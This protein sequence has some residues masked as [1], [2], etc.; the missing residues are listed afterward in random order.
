[1]GEA[2][3]NRTQRTVA[4]PHCTPLSMRRRSVHTPR[5]Q[6][7]SLPSCGTFGCGEDH[8]WCLEGRSGGV[9]LIGGVLRDVILVSA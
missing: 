9:S 8:R 3:P 4:A 7:R 5:P 1:M 6:S 2:R